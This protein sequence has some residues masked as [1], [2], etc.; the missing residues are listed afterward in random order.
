MMA[1]A[2]DVGLGGGIQ[3][4]GSNLVSSA[5][6]ITRQS[7]GVTAGSRNRPCGP[8]LKGRGA[9]REKPLRVVAR[10]L[11]RARPDAVVGQVHD[12][13]TS[14]GPARQ[15][16][17][18]HQPDP[19]EVAG[20]T[21]HRC[22]QRPAPPSRPT[23]SEDQPRRIFWLLPPKQVA[24]QRHVPYAPRRVAV[25]AAKEVAAVEAEMAVV[26]SHI[27]RA[28]LR[29][30]ADHRFGRTSPPTWPARIDGQTTMRG[31]PCEAQGFPLPAAPWVSMFRH[32]SV[33]PTAVS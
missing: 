31:E 3:H 26:P 29:S 25:V 21:H 27:S 23:A 30:L 28:P 20:R 12:A 32:W 13:S 15:P 2:D 19:T 5:T 8:S 22:R 7:H 4:D 16:A 33:S 6:G 18:G 24:G 9:K 11:P 14:T 17:Q 10:S 1:T